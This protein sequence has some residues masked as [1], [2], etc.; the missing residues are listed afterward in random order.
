MVAVMSAMDA[1]G[2]VCW[3]DGGWGFAFAVPVESCCL[4]AGGDELGADHCFLVVGGAGE[5]GPLQ[6]EGAQ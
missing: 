2:K 5:P 1:S 6:A 3:G 4:A